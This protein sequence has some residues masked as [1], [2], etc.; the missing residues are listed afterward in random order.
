MWKS[1]PGSYQKHVFEGDEYFQAG[2]WP[3][4]PGWWEGKGRVNPPQGFERERRVLR[5]GPPSLYT[6]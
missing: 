5:I 3:A 2:S 6:P 1:G 4:E